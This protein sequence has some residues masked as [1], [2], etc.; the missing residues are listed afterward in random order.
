MPHTPNRDICLTNKA[1]TYLLAG[2]P[3]LLSRTTAQSE[4][5]VEL[6]D[7]TEL[8]DIYDTKG[9]A[10]ALDVSKKKRADV[11][12]ALLRDHGKEPL[13]QVLERYGFVAKPDTDA[14][15][16]SIWPIARAIFQGPAARARV[17]AIIEEFF[18]S[19]AK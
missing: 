13:G 19:E 16:R 9:V 3:V 7:A 6:G 18:A 10:A 8:V 14:V 12:A 2:I 11:M 1:F 15:A 17:S 5:A 4:L